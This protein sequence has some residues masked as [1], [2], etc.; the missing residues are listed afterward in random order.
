MLPI[1]FRKY[2]HDKALINSKVTNNP[3]N[4]I[5][6]QLEKNAWK[7]TG[8]GSATTDCGRCGGIPSL[9]LLMAPEQ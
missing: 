4:N 9:D 7:L 6:A 1:S 3:V 2:Q 5:A 8:G